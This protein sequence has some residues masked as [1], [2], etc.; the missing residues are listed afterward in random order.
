MR[1]HSDRRCFACKE[2][3][4]KKLIYSHKREEAREVEDNFQR[5]HMD[6]GVTDTADKDDKSA[7]IQSVAAKTAIQQKDPYTSIKS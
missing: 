6:G 2:E 7:A 3:L 4:P 5:K 1:Q